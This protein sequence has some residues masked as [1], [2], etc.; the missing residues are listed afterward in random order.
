[1]SLVFVILLKKNHNNFRIRKN[2]KRKKIKFTGAHTHKM[3]NYFKFQQTESH[4][5]IW[6]IKYIEKT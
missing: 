5:Y 2:G 4:E 6:T 3:E 1:M